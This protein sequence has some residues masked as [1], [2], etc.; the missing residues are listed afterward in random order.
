V[1]SPLERRLCFAKEAADCAAPLLRAALHA[2]TPASAGR[3]A[4]LEAAVAVLLAEKAA[5][6]FT[7]ASA[8]PPPPPTPAPEPPAASPAPA[9]APSSAATSEDGDDAELRAAGGISRYNAVLVA[10]TV[11][12]ASPAKAERPRE[13]LFSDDEIS[14]ARV[15]RLAR[16]SRGRALT[17]S[18]RRSC[19]G[20]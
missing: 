1:V 3:V 15:M 4:R 5:G 17:R 8:G 13:R 2:C 11:P 19:D 9:P 6:G 10:A 16:R 18:V 7:P 20:L 14:G 12:A